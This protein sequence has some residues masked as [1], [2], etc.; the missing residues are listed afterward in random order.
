MIKSQPY[1]QL[2]LRPEFRFRYFSERFRLYLFIV[3]FLL[4][5]LKN[6]WTTAL[7]PKL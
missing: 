2:I 5:C 6:R 1:C 3:V 4:D 7:L